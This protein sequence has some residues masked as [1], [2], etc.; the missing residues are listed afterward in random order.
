[1]HC[2]QNVKILLLWCVCSVFSDLSCT[3]L[4]SYTV[5]QGRSRLSQTSDTRN[6]HLLS[7]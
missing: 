6:L 1:M 4:G 3:L 7:N 2:Q 5:Q